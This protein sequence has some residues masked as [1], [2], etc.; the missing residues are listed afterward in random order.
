MTL[1]FNMAA[2]LD[3]ILSEHKGKPKRTKSETDRNGFAFLAHIRFQQW[4][5]S[6][7]V[8]EFKQESDERIFGQGTAE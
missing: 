3:S 6:G 4:K 2:L 8:L 5:I 1:G 7:S